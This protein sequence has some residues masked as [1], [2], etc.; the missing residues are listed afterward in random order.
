MRTYTTAIDLW[1]VGCIFAEI[2]KGDPIFP[3]EGEIDQMTKIFR[4]LGA[5]NESIWPGSSMLPNRS[6]V[7]YK[8]PTR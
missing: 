6:K 4:M 1:S 8:V 7:S 5:P 2:M 3:G